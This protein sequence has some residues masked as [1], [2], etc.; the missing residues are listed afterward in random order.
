MALKPPLTKLPIRIADSGFYKGFSRHVTIPGKLLIGAL[1]IWA[2]AFPDQAGTVLGTFNSFILQNFATWYV[3]VIA[4]FITVCLGL[5]VWP[6]AGRLKLGAVGD[7]PEFTNFSWFSMMFGAGIGVGMLTWAV[8]EPMYHFNDNPE[9]I[10]GLA[11]GAAADNIRN[12]YKWSFLHWGLSAWASYAIV[13]LS[14][15]YFS[16]RR[17]LPL[18]VRSGLT[19]LFGRAMSGPLGHVVDVVAV[20]ATIL[21]VAQTL[22]FGVEQFVA[23]MAR[24]GIGEWLTNEAG[25]AS[26]TG[27]IVA[28]VIIMSAST[29][30]ALSGVGK[31]IKWLSNINMVLSIALLGFFLIFGSTLFGLQALAVGIWDYLLALP[32]MSVRVWR[33]DGTETGDALAGWQGAWTVFYW[34][35][36]VAFAPF[37]GVFLARISKGRTTREFVL[38]AMIVPA[39]MCFVW[40]T[41]AGGTAIDLELNGAASGVIASAPDGDKI[42][43]MTGFMLSPLLGWLMAV[44]I[45][46]LL[47]TYLVTSADS[48]VL[49]VNT[50]NAAGDEG[51]KARPHII[52]WGVALGAVVA[53][54]LLVGGL[55]AIQTAMVIGALP[56][57]LVMLLMCVALIKAILRD[58]QREKAGISTR[59]PGLAG[60]PPA[61]PVA[62]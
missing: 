51:P 4:A 55:T 59:A 18:T 13:G 62:G 30:S 28:I 16:Y 53:A 61:E 46:V 40:F 21:G 57:S 12:A 11:T 1:V 38:G 9:V 49:I 29:L 26:P 14:L 15:A 34:A 44:M 8:A 24:I 42:F 19:P 31:G 22:G 37:V 7:K 36:W 33:A 10:Q 43:A 48:A 47:M 5:A 20:V 17:L 2:V 52:F 39:L 50:I 45:V 32:E 25:T 60:G 3:W 56:F 6:A 41:W 23:G 54:L 35:W 58:T 27:I